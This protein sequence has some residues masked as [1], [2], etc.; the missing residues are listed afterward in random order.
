MYDKPTANI[1]NGEKLKAFPLK[2]GTRQRCPLL[3]LLFNIV[4]EVLARAIRKE[5]ERKGIQIGKEDVKL[6]L[7]ADDM[8]LYIGALKTPP[9]NY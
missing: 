8:I 1:I 5:K 7:F 4:L 2:S 9:Q 3:S 6:S